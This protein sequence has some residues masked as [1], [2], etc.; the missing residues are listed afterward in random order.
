MSSQHLGDSQFKKAIEELTGCL[1]IDAPSFDHC[2]K[3]ASIGV[4]LI[5]FLMCL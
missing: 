4:F 2:L 3:P 5:G 1:Q